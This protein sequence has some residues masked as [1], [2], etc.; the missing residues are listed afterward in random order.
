MLSPSSKD[1]TVKSWNVNVID[2]RTFPPWSWS[3]EA[4]SGSAVNTMTILEDGR[5]IT[6]S[7]STIKIWD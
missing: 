6:G 2:E 7:D 5:L 1:G 3:L 4:H